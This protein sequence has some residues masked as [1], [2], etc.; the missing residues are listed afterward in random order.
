M[1]GMARR[2]A[3]ASR[4]DQP[5]PEQVMARKEDPLPVRATVPRA[6][7]AAL[8]GSL[9]SGCTSATPTVPSSGAPGPPL[10]SA[11]PG[12]SAAPSPAASGAS[13]LVPSGSPSTGPAWQ[14]VADP[15]LVLPDGTMSEVIRGGPGFVAVGGG[16]DE[17]TR[18]PI[19]AIWTSVDGR[20]WRRAT[21]DGDAGLGRVS[22]IAVGGPGLVAVGGQCCPDEAAVWV[23]EDGVDWVRI[24]DQEA[25]TGTAMTAVTSWAGGLV[26]VGCEAQLECA[27][28]AIWVSGDGQGWERSPLSEELGSAFL[29]DITAIGSVLVA[30]GSSQPQTPGPATILVSIDAHIWTP[31]E[32]PSGAVSLAGVAS[33]PAGVVATGTA[34]DEATGRSDALVLGSADGAAWQRR[35]SDSFARGATEDILSGPRGFVAVGQARRGGQ[36]VAA[37]WSSPDGRRWERLIAGG[38]GTMSAVAM[39]PEGE[40]VAVGSVTSDSVTRPAVWVMPGG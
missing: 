15:D 39:G 16:Y 19:A 3:A 6:M 30:V 20:E 9:L 5:S 36:G 7:L 33:G 2:S 4:P 8:L 23:S 28:T 24:P 25:F 35:D 37:S 26:A 29:A 38:R 18:T 34:F 1:G 17:A 27:G 40:L 32:V 21:L 22:S 12:L 13:P 31:A 10:D 14:L 11:V